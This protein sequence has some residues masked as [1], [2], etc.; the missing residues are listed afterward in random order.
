MVQIL[1]IPFIHCFIAKPRLLH[2]YVIEISMHELS[3]MTKSQDSP[4]SVNSL[5]NDT[6][7]DWTKLKAFA[8]DKFNVAKLLIFF[9][10][11]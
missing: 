9:L 2:N 11:D 8:D 1:C 7:L 5:P 10:I 6:I 3:V 4:I